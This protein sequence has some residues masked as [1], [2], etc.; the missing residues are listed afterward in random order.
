[1][2]TPIVAPQSLL[3]SQDKLLLAIGRLDPQKG[4]RDLIAAFAASKARRHEWK[5]VILGEGD[6]R[7][8]LESL[9]N[10][11]DLTGRVLLPGWVGNVSD[12]YAAA[13]LFALSSHIEGF[14][15]VLLEAMA[16]GLACVSYDCETGPAEIIHDG[17]NGRLVSLMQG[18]AGLAAA[19]DELAEDDEARA[20]L[21]RNAV[22]V[23]RKYTPVSVLGIWARVLQTVVEPWTKL[24]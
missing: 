9:I 23:R 12:W 13:Q 14:P 15:N 16:H 8:E 11:L 7:V 2:T 17:Q 6:E 10:S 21:A 20:K 3:D 4:F 22:E 19:I 5:L 18:S 24:A 1:M